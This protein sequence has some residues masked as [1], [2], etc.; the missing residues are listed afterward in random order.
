V[1]RLLLLPTKN[2]AHNMRWK[3]M[4]G[5]LNSGRFEYVG[6][7]EFIGL[8]EGVREDVDLEEKKLEER[9][10]RGSLSRRNR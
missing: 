7:S 10:R 3:K 2:H 1:Q 4:M 8:F 5:R 9:K 6:L